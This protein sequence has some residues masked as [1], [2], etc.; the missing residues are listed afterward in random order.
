MSWKAISQGLVAV[1]C[2]ACVGADQ[3]SRTEESEAGSALSDTHVPEDIDAVSDELAGHRPRSGGFHPLR[4][5]HPRRMHRGQMVRAAVLRR[6]RLR[7]GEMSSQAGWRLKIFATSLIVIFV[8]LYG[9][10]LGSPWVAIQLVIITVPMLMVKYQEE[11]A[12]GRPIPRVD[13]KRGVQGELGFRYSQAGGKLAV[14]LCFTV[15]ALLDLLQIEGWWAR[16]GV[17]TVPQSLMVTTSL[18]IGAG[19]LFAYV[20]RRWPDEPK[21][22]RD[23]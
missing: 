7:G 6:R 4:D 19:H 1:M 23:A 20:C 12:K 8:S 10:R 9:V 5:R 22:E 14:F 3:T 17:S 16:I 15:G 13:R 11:D 21:E 18:I 2:P